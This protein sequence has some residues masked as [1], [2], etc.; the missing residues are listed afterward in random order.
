MFLIGGNCFQV[1]RKR[2]LCVQ[3]KN[4]L[5]ISNLFNIIA[6]YYVASLKLFCCT[7]CDSL[8]FD[9]TTTMKH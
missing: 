8:E 9:F 6:T 3:A 7:V 2:P 1:V 5:G 4:L